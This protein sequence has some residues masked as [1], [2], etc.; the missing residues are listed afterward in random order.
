MENE[1]VTLRLTDGQAFTLRMVLDFVGGDRVNSP[2]KHI[3]AI[4]DM[5]DDQ[6]VF[7]ATEENTDRDIVD[8]DDAGI[9]FRDYA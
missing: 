9:Y 2:R 1:P 4:V 3:Q 7:Y 8:P 6:G 5:L